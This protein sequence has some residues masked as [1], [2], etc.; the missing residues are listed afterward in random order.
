MLRKQKGYGLMEASMAI[1][2]MS[3]LTAATIPSYQ[4]YIKRAHYLEIL[5][6]A[7]PLKLAVEQCFDTYNNLN[8]CSSKSENFR[9]ISKEPADSII[10][11]A[12]VIEGTI[13]ITPKAK[14]GFSEKDDYILTPKNDNGTLVWS[15]NGGGVK[16]GYTALQ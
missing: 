13:K 2:I 7:Q 5:N 9:Q 4:L 8:Q 1:T 11:K 3:I 15:T 14:Y 16:N 6:K 10:K 12:E